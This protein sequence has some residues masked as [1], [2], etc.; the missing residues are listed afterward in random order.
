MICLRGSQ[1]VRKALEETFDIVHWELRCG[2]VYYGHK[3]WNGIGTPTNDAVVSYI[4]VDIYSP[5]GKNLILDLTQD[6]IVNKLKEKLGDWTPDFIWAS[7]ICNK[8]SMVLTG[9]GGNYYFEFD[10]ENDYIKPRENWD[11]KVQ[12]HMNKYNNEEGRDKA[13]NDAL[14]ALKMH[15]NTK[16]IINAFNV[17]FAIE[18]P[19]SAMSEY[20][21]K[22]KVKNVAHY[23]AYGFDY[24]KPTAIYSSIDLNLKKCSGGHKHATMIGEKNKPKPTHWDK[25]LSTYANRSSVPPMLIKEIIKQLIQ[26]EE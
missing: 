19:A 12:R 15:E 2:Y 5:E 26:E 25:N 17:P 14:L 24:K 22:D 16:R 23:C 1:S 4:G 9:K 18:N 7:P 3:K 8:F 10:K 6:D 21:W 20:I 11:I 13:R